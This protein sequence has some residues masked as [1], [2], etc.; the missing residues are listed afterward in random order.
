MDDRPLLPSILLRISLASAG[1]DHT[2][3]VWD[4]HAGVLQRT[5]VG[6][7]K[8]VTDVDFD[9]GGN[10]LVTGPSRYGISRKFG[11]SRRHSWALN[12]PC[13]MS[14]SYRVINKSSVAVATAQSGY[15]MWCQGILVMQCS[16]VCQFAN[17]GSTVT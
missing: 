3:R 16:L 7:T 9:R 2:I 8:A 13:L 6:H 5:L 4:W 17:R 1:E 11:K 12:T 15:V 14:A 10:L